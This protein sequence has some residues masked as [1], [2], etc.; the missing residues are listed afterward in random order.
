MSAQSTLFGKLLISQ[1]AEPKENDKLLAKLSYGI[2]KNLYKLYQKIQE[3]RIQKGG[4]AELAA[5]RFY[6]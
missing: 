1:E 6:R 4:R 5:F 3:T 2:G